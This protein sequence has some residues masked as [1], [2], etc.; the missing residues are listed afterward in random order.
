MKEKPDFTFIAVKQTGDHTWE[1]CYGGE[2]TH[3][4]MTTKDAIFILKEL[5]RKI[6]P[7]LVDHSIGARFSTQ[8]PNCGFVAEGFDTAEEAAAWECDQC[9]PNLP[10][11][12]SVDEG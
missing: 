8:C 4:V 1:G 6:P 10:G 5:Q 11:F 9:Q 12:D 2:E 3:V 7:D